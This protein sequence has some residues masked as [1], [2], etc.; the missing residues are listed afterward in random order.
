MAN[1]GRLIETLSL[2]KFLIELNIKEEWVTLVEALPTLFFL[3]G[4]LHKKLKIVKSED[5]VVCFC[6]PD[7]KQRHYPYSMVRREYQ[8]AFSLYQVARLVKRPPDQVQKFLKNKL[9]DKPSGFEY[10]IASRRPKNKYWSQDD[11]LELRDR[12]YSL[13]PKNKDG[14][15]ASNFVLASRA[16]MLEE[17]IGETSYYVR[18]SDGTYLQVWKAI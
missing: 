2:P 18:S 12:L 16:E 3:N 7:E 5:L 10:H 9:I 11:A 1:A 6:F 14:F 13:A 4:K 17:M 8:K 15:P